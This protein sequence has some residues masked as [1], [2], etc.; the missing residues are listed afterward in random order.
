MKW[1]QDYNKTPTPN[2]VGDLMLEC[3]V[4]VTKAE[5][6]LWLELSKGINRFEAKWDLASGICTLLQAGHGRQA[7]GPR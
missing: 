1:G 5:G 7:S 2:W 4:H 3:N 6:E